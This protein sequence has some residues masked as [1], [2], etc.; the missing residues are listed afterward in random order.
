MFQNLFQLDDLR[1]FLT[2]NETRMVIL[3]FENEPRENGTFVVTYVD[4]TEQQ[5]QNWQTPVATLD[6]LVL[7][8]CANNDTGPL[9]D[10][11]ESFF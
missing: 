2:Q 5:D 10:Y 9:M 4:F 7:D 3:Y 11:L 6:Q 1:L 8:G